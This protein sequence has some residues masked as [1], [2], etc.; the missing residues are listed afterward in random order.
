MSLVELVD[1]GVRYRIRRSQD[2]HL[3]Y[4]LLGRTGS[5]ARRWDDFWALRGVTF[6]IDPGDAVAVVGDNG[7]GKSTLCKVLA[8][9]LMPDAGHVA[10]HGRVSP[11]LGLGNGFMPDLTGAENIALSGALM[12]LA[13]D[14]VLERTP[15][16]VEFA[17]LGDFI[18]NPVRMYSSGMRA[19]LGF[20]IAT[21]I[22]PDVLILDEVLSVGDTSFK[23]KCLARMQSLMQSARAI[24]LVTHALEQ[25]EALAKSVLWLEHGRIKRHGPAHEVLDAYRARTQ[26]GPDGD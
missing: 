13:P 15:S 9:I 18:D 8:D 2:R 21:A 14:E 6:S 19:R 12:G 24:V 16:I 23:E 25:A 10:V 5:E 1:V 3:R 7:A 4:R 20:A 22:E 26:N 17:D 11:V